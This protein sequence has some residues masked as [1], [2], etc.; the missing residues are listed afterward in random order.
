MSDAA[1]VINLPF[2]RYHRPLSLRTN[3]VPPIAVTLIN[4]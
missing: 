2:A 1:A 3:L 4:D